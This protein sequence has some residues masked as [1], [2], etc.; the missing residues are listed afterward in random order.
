[1]EDFNQLFDDSLLNI[2]KVEDKTI[3]LKEGERRMV[4]ILFADVKGFTALSESLDHE[5][6]Q[7][8]V[9]QLMKIFS[10]CVELHGGYVD[11]YTG[12]QIMALFGAKK[13]SEV[14][15]QRSVN[16]AMFMLKKLAQFNQ[17]LK[18]SDKYK[19][20]NIDLSLRIGINTGM[21]TTGAVGK[22]REGDYTVYGDTVNL[23]ARME[24]NAP[25]NSIMIPEETMELIQDHF[26]FK[27]HGTIK[28][29]GKSE[30]ISVF[31]VDSKKDLSINL[32]TPFIG[33]EKEISTL[34]KV[35]LKQIKEIKNNIFDKINFIGITAEA[36]TGKTRLISEYLKINKNK[37]LSICH[38][39]NISSK[40][41]YLFI[42]LIKDVFKI[43]QMD[44]KQETKNKFEEGIANLKKENSHYKEQIESAIP[45]IGFLIG[46]SYQDSRLKDRN[47]LQNHLNISIKTLL[48]AICNKANSNNLPYILVLDDLHWIDKMSTSMLDYI[49]NTLNIENNRDESSFSQILILATYRTEYKIQNQLKENLN[50][51]EIN[52]SCLKKEDSIKLIKR[53]TKDLKLES[54][55]IS[56]LIDKSKGNPFFIEE[57]ISLLKEK[58]N[59]AESIDE[60]RGIKNVYEVPRSINA[61]I[62]ARIDSLEKTL[63]LLLQKAT[64]IG[65]DFF[66]QILSQLEKKLGVNDDIDKPVHTLENEDF[67]HHYINELDHY[68]FKHML[69]RDVA[70]STILISN[71]ILLH[72]AVAEIIEEYFSDKIETFYFDLAIHYDISENYDKALEYLYLAG[73]KHQS[74]FDFTHAIQCFERIAVIIT[75]KNPYKEKITSENLDLEENYCYKLYYQSKVEL[76]RVF[77]QIGKWDQ[78]KKILDE[79]LKYNIK[80][81][82][83]NY[84]IFKNLGEYHSNKREHK[85]ATGCL[86]KCLKIAENDANTINIATIKGSL[87][88][89]EHDIGN[90]NEALKGFKEELELFKNEK[91][92]LGIAASQG[93]IGMV[94]FQQGDLNQALIH[95]KEKYNIAKKHDSRQMILQGLG[96]IALIHNIRGEYDKS[97]KI[98][99]EVMSTAEDIYDLNA[100]SQTYGNKGIIYKNIK[101][102]DKAI[103]NYKKQIDISSKM[104]DKFQQANAYDGLGIISRENVDY[105][106]SKKSLNKAI[107]LSKAINDKYGI[108]SSHCNLAITYFESGS[109]NEAKETLSIGLKLFSEMNN[110]R[111]LYLGDFLM[112]EI[113]LF[114]NEYKSGIERIN[115]AI[116][117]FEE[118]NDT[119]YLI[120]SLIL[121][122]KL[123]R[124]NNNKEEALLNLNK[125]KKLSSKINHTEFKTEV[126]IEEN[127]CALQIDSKANNLLKHIEGKSDETKA[128]IYFNIYKYLNDNSAKKKASNLYSK[129]YKKVNKFKYKYYLNLLK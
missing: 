54:K 128:Y 22:E 39:S 125:A 64:I 34:Q 46:L 8:L 73:K 124:L 121:L 43:S 28:V 52:L 89:C 71:K 118:I 127:I 38:A 106:E 7:T 111:G 119:I 65:E 123:N 53:S 15:T 97:L 42:R 96:N 83:I 99:E 61:L 26:I 51:K 98:Y 48:K 31:L 94:L 36:G 86:R 27:D 58:N 104:G 40:P 41:Y 62:L 113:F 101:E 120:K 59:Y 24:S 78:S 107:E 12:D 110:K 67:I 117:F 82:N 2:D 88:H 50:F 129:L 1:M 80:N 108:A 72:K 13:A 18:K 115:K 6:V 35:Y 66:I 84:N 47:E 33:R 93:H 4:A 3:R 109:I 105:K 91:D 95:F 87:A 60:S 29:K 44:S 11:K 32:S 68:K 19:D 81:Q 70:Y 56:D 55:V 112:A 103:K 69:T 102:Y 23:A 21:V 14:D 122:S 126:S 57:W 90:T 77:L 100:Q 20:L 5:E 16:T 25:V 30:P 114:N 74:L 49:I 79:L 17:I 37:H 75:E 76:S 9:D 45:F 10:H 116:L 92:E 63:K 85:E